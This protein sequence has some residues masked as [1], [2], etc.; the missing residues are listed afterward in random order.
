MP[1]C[2][3]SAYKLLATIL[4]VCFLCAPIRSQATSW[5]HTHLCDAAVEAA[6]A[7]IGIPIHILRAIAR[8]ES[9][10]SRGGQFSPWPWTVNVAGK[11][12]YYENKRA[13][14]S[15]ILKSMEDGARNIDIGCFQINHKWHGSQFSSIDHMLDPLE[16]ARYAASFLKALY[17]EFG[18][19]ELAAGAYHSRNIESSEKYLSRLMP[20]LDDLRPGVPRRFSLGGLRQNFIAPLRPVEGKTRQTPGSLFPSAASG[21]GSLFGAQDIR[22]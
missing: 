2:R 17:A 6:S 11:G 21:R 15:H 1:H 18:Q 20:I 14:K 8:A 19:W 16:N 10:L 5:I 7:E 4:T 3:L 13:A 9:G 22:G 12:A